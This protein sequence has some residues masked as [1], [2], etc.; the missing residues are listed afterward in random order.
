MLC[1]VHTV[2]SIHF[3]RSAG[4]GFLVV[5]VATNTMVWQNNITEVCGTILLARK[6]DV[7][8]GFPLSV[9]DAFENG[10]S[11]EIIRS[12]QGPDDTSRFGWVIITEV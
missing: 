9:P 10:D 5:T 3:S 6:A 8:P 4:Y 11:V 7:I 2:A 12:K 1:L